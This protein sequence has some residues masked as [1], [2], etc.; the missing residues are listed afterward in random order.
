MVLMVLWCINLS[1]V[2]LYNQ[3]KLLGRGE[4]ESLPTLVIVAYYD[5][6]GLV[7][8]SNELICQYFYYV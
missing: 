5:A 4:E 7:T 1:F 3:G 6:S 8:V 2:M